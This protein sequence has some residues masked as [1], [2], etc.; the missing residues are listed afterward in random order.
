[1]ATTEAPN[2]TFA[3]TASGA[4]RNHRGDEEGKMRKVEAAAAPRRANVRRSRL[5][6]GAV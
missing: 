1:M 4:A 3:Q 6:W 2:P 5:R